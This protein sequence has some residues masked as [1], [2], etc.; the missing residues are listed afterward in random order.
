MATKIIE[1]LVDDLDGS[2]AAVTKT[3]AVDG[4]RYEIDL[5]EKNADEFMRLLGAYIG[6]G[7]RLGRVPAGSI[8][9][10]NRAADNAAMRRYAKANGLSTSE[11]GRVPVEVERAWIE[12][13]RPR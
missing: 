2:D 12:A 9:R 1:R 4:M 5:S 13:G 10:T 3:F 7:R 11:R 6:A 8:A